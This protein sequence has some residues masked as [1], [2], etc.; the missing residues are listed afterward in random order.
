[1]KGVILCAGKAKRMKP[2]SSTLP[3]TL[4]PVANR[5]LLEHCINRMTDIGIEEIGIV[6]NPQQKSIVD[7]LASSNLP[8]TFR[9]IFQTEQLGVAHALASAQEFVGTD[10][11]LLL[12]GDNLTAEPLETLIAASGGDKSALLLA[13][14]DTPQDYGI[15]E[16]SDNRI[17][18]IEEK[19][20]RP[21]SKLAVIGT[22]LFDA[23][24]FMA[25]QHIQPS[26]RGEYEITDAIQWLIQHGFPLAYSITKE[27]YTDVGTLQRW[28][29]A[30]RWML[31][32]QL[33]NEVQVGAQTKLENCVL[34]GPVIIGNQCTLKNA[35]VGPYVSIQDGTE[36]MNC[37]IEN[38]ICLKKAR[39]LDIPSPV[40]HSIFGQHVTL[41]G[42]HMQESSL[43]FILGSDSHLIFPA[44]GGKGDTE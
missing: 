38:S 21:R 23:N 41:Q 37:T 2:F 29:E 33:G 26:A 15:A 44:S 1:M 5:S 9:Y 4:L 16:I 17:V 43:R 14:V 11:F 28:L 12:L 18:S 3:K 32:R 20:K 42:V 25:I 34:K 40:S 19:P 39:I 24:I 7:Y 10:S 27:P 8:V 6:M 31:S 30:N 36:L 22:Y 35:V 13:E